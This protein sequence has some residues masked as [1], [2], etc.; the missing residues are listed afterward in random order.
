M[1]SHTSIVY[2]LYIV[3]YTTSQHEDIRRT[4]QA[5]CP[6][7]SYEDI[8]R[9]TQAYFPPQSY[10]DIR[11]TTQSYWPPQSYEDIRRT[12]QSY[13]LDITRLENDSHCCNINIYS[14]GSH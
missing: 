7:Q 5:Y 14:V 6:P 13:C 4:T 3:K 12:T 9:T 8:R 2:L 11:R 10:E 1:T